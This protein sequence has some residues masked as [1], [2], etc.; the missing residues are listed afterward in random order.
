MPLYYQ[1]LILFHLIYSGREANDS[2]KIEPNH[3]TNQEP[4]GEKTRKE[5]DFLMFPLLLFSSSFHA[6]W[7]PY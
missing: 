3:F 4:N 6:L 5:Y 7:A 2:Q 1:F